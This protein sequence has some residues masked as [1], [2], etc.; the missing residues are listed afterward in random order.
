MDSLG[1]V[2]NFRP[3]VCLFPTTRSLGRS[4]KRGIV[5]DFQEL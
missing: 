4:E 3:L 5:A 1:L 2:D